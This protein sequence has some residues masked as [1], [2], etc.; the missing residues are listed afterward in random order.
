MVSVESIDGE[1]RDRLHYQS[2]EVSE[3]LSSIQTM[4]RILLNDR[5]QMKEQ[6]SSARSP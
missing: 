5:R 6:P 3:Q 4:L 2:V 1:G